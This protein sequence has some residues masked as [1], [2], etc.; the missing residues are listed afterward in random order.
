MTDYLVGDPGLV[1]G[2]LAAPVPDDEDA[3]S[4]LLVLGRRV[5]HPGQ[6]GR[7]QEKRNGQDDRRYEDDSALMD[8]HSRH[9]QASKDNTQQD[10]REYIYSA[11]VG[12]TCT[13]RQVT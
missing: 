6:L 1:V 10:G 8:R 11:V 13:R 3:Q 2:A 7:S 4:P 9:P 12:C 5:L